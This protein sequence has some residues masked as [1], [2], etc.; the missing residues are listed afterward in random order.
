[1]S[2]RELYPTGLPVDVGAHAHASTSGRSAGEEADRAQAAAT[3]RLREIIDRHCDFVWRTMRYLGVEESG[4]EDAAQQVLCVLARRLGEIAPGA[5]MSFLFSTAVR[6]ASEVRRAARRRPTADDSEV[7]ALVASLPSPE[8]LVDQSRA[9]EVLRAV[10]EAIPTDLRV[11]FILFEIEELTLAQIAAL[12]GIPAG[13]A[14]SR[15][16]RAR[17]SFQGI[18]RRMH[19]RH[20]PVV[21]GGE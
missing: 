9:R 15:L 1:M 3:R 8:E 2:A 5:E 20:R 17:E 10:L 7:D 13:T 11:V 18:V 14:A 4:V 16:R 12:V 6:V 21:G 19:A